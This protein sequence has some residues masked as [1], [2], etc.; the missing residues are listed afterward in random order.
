VTLISGLRGKTVLVT[1]ASRGIGAACA[2][3]FAAEGAHVGLAGRDRTALAGVREDIGDT[4]VAFAADIGTP[5]GIRNL[6]AMVAAD[7]GH[8]DVL[9]NN[10]GVSFSRAAEKI[11]AADIERVMGVNLH[12][13]LALALDLGPKMAARGDGV[14]ITVSSMS[15]VSG[16]NWASVYAASK[17]GTHGFTRALANELGPRGVRVNAVCPG[18]VLTDMW[19]AP[20]DR[21]DVEPVLLEQVALRRWGLAEEIAAVI[22]F[23]ASDG[24]RYVSGQTIVVDGGMAGMIQ[25]GGGLVGAPTAL[26]PDSVATS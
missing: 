26:Q 24:G 11:T 9:V 10:A 23:L 20:E 7:L 16:L 3:T 22:A 6:L 4:A 14:I 2:R 15:G 25:G 8:V 5:D 13:P 18:L 1:G 19:G 17:A 12:S 21:R